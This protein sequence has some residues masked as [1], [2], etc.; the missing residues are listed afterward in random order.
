MGKISWQ[1]QNN[2]V[3]ILC[4]QFCAPKEVREHLGV[5]G[6]LLEHGIESHESRFDFSFKLHIYIYN[7]VCPPIIKEN[8]G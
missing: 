1:F 4:I 5:L 2:L 8:G 6:F 7:F 3:D